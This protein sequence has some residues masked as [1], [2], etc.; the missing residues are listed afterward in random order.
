VLDQPDT[1][2][3]PGTRRLRLDGFSPLSYGVLWRGKATP[4]IDG[5]LQEAVRVA[6]QLSS[7]LTS[8]P[9]NHAGVRRGPAL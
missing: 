6:A 8:T 3:P 7:A 2:A 9:E 5:F 4:L 1:P